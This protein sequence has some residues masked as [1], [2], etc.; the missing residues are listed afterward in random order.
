MKKLAYLTLCLILLLSLC[1]CGSEGSKTPST[2]VTTQSAEETIETTVETEPMLFFVPVADEEFP[3]LLQ[4][5][6]TK[7]QLAAILCIA[8]SNYSGMALSDATVSNLVNGMVNVSETLD[9]EV[10]TNENWQSTCSVETLN[11][12]LSV[13]TDY[14]LSENTH[15]T[16]IDG[17][18]YSFY[19]AG[20]SNSSVTIHAAEH[21]G[22]QMRIE[23]TFQYYGPIPEDDWQEDRIAILEIN[24]N[25][26]YQI[27]DITIK[28][29]WDVIE[30][31]L[32]SDS[33][34]WK[35]ACMK[36][37]LDTP[38]MSF[39]Y[40]NTRV[41]T[42]P[43]VRYRLV[44][45][46]GNGT[47]ELVLQATSSEEGSGNLS[48]RNSWVGIY[49]FDNGEPQQLYVNV[50]Y[51]P[52]FAWDDN[53]Q[54]LIIYSV[55]AFNGSAT[56]YALTME[57]STIRE[58]VIFEGYFADLDGSNEYNADH[59]YVSVSAAEFDDFSILTDN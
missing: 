41:S 48:F 23:Y 29:H 4:G 21:N 32:P 55:D 33:P 25:G 38:D 56:Y 51:Q 53:A 13:L 16:Q 35:R 24:T 54:S 30:Q 12:I 19:G 42:N 17:D 1:A 7:E 45:L 10:G 37:L 26:L 9:I 49:T 14:R 28:E 58:S 34:S 43:W 39:T 40:S 22:V 2:T 50:Y 31:V 27:T 59:G 18:T 36:L 52:G 5:G 57:G 15:P 47:P 44:D 8:P 3:G 6:M 11:R 20:G 46:N